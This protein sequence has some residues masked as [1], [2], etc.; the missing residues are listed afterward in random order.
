MLERRA[1]HHSPISVAS[2]PALPEPMSGTRDRPMLVEESP[3][4]QYIMV[5]DSLA[6]QCIFCT[7]HPR[8]TPGVLGS[9]SVHCCGGIPG[10][11]ERRQRPPMSCHGISGAY[12]GPGPYYV[13]S[14]Y[15]WH[16]RSYIPSG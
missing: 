2:W 11:Y 14:A 16:E 5:E 15:E 10:A 1:L 13:S 12:G 8:I 7:V 9:P 6:P 3:G 4:P